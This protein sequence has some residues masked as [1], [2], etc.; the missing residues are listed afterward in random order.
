[1]QAGG[2]QGGKIS[3]NKIEANKSSQKNVNKS[4][5]ANL[6]SEISKRSKGGVNPVGLRIDGRSG[7]NLAN[8]QQAQLGIS[9][10]SMTDEEFK[11]AI[12]ALRREPQ[13]SLSDLKSRSA[14]I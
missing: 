12:I 13:Q 5:A 7:V 3:Q 6:A 10:E 4:E 11:T 14:N 8:V 2:T 1:M 9:S